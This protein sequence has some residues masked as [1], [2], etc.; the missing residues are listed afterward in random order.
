MLSAMVEEAKNMFSQE[1]ITVEDLEDKLPDVSEADRDVRGVYC[2]VVYHSG[3]VYVY[4]GSSGNLFARIVL[5]DRRI[6]HGDTSITLYRT[7]S[8]MGTWNY[9]WKTLARFPLGTHQSFSYLLE[10]ICMVVFRSI[11]NSMNRRFHNGPSRLMYSSLMGDK[12][13]KDYDTTFEFETQPINHQSPLLAGW[14]MLDTSCQ[15][16]HV[17]WVPRGGGNS[18]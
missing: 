3:Y 8:G 5:H 1:K 2:C 10:A 6:R 13:D 17:W 11:D 12:D 18:L 9:R 4:I 14:S 16:V 15:E 7:L